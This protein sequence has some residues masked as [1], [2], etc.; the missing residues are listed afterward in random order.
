MAI[1]AD[2]FKAALACWASGVTI[3]TVAQDGLYYGLTVSS[4][5]SVSLDPPLVSVCL[6]HETRANAMIEATGRFAVSV[7]AEDQSEASNVFAASGRVPTPD[8]DPFAIELTQDGLPALRGALSWLQCR[9]HQK[10][11]AGDHVVW[12]GE[13]EQTRSNASEGAPLM[14]FRRGYRGVRDL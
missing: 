1:D 6:N 8:L 11:L 3:V 13:V 4:F 12:L 7:L 5:S 10:V 14:Y 9:V 2:A